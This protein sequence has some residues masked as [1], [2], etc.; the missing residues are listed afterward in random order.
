MLENNSSIFIDKLEKKIAETQILDNMPKEIK[1][2]MSP[3]FIPND[4]Q[5]MNT[6]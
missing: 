1:H 5:N 4:P 3:A 2:L 6:F